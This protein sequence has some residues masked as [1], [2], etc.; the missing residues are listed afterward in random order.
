MHGT[1]HNARPQ[2]PRGLAKRGFGGF[3][4]EAMAIIV[5]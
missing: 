5:G 2:M 4:R 1:K 3:I